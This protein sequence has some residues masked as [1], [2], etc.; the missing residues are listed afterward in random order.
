[1]GYGSAYR[2]GSRYSLRRGS[3]VKRVPMAK[4]GMGTKRKYTGKSTSVRSKRSRTRTNT[5]TKSKKERV[6]RPPASGIS[7]SYTRVGYGKY[8][9][10]TKGRTEPAIIES[11]T[12]GG[13]TTAGTT[14]VQVAQLVNSSL[15][16]QE[17]IN[18]VNDSGSQGFS[19]LSKFSAN[20]VAGSIGWK[21]GLDSVLHKTQYTNQEG[22]TATLII[23]DFVSKRDGTSSQF[24]VLAL[25]ASS[26]VSTGTLNSANDGLVTPTNST[27]V[28]FV[29]PTSQKVVNQF[30][31][32]CRKTKVE[33]GPGRCH[34]H[35]FYQ[36]LNR[37]IDTDMLFASAA[38]SSSNVKGI[39]Y[40]CV[41]IA[42]GVPTDSSTTSAVGTVSLCPVKIVW[43]TSHKTVSRLISTQSRAYYNRNNLATN[44]TPHFVSEGSGVIF[45][46]EQVA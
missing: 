11:T 31:T 6:V 34:E 14:G 42:Y 35:V 41:A 23:Y 9:R 7:N 18:L 20:P 24:D 46:G 12:S 39:T 15:T 3:S 25:W 26:M 36:K 33:L 29:V 43:C 37:V 5:T 22:Q 44:V 28:P 38:P 8:S 21:L 2:N 32:M 19:S 16:N 17:I 45:N 40:Q 1:M 27:N 30:W 4:R 13:L 10:G